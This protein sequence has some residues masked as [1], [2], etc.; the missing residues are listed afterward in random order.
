M[1]GRGPTLLA[2]LKDI[3]HIDLT[4]H[5]QSSGRLIRMYDLLARTAAP[6]HLA[7]SGIRYVRHTSEYDIDFKLAISCSHVETLASI[8][9]ASTPPGIRT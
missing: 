3:R 1:D 9:A 5:I 7:H 6:P 4:R 8:E 2:Y